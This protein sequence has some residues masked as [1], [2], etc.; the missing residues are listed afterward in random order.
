MLEFGFG[1]TF[2]LAFLRLFTTEERENESQKNVKIE[3]RKEKR[4]TKT[5]KVFIFVEG[6][7]REV[8]IV[9]NNSFYLFYEWQ[10]NGSK[11]EKSIRELRG[12]RK[13]KRKIFVV[14]MKINLRIFFFYFPLFLETVRKLKEIRKSITK[15]M[16]FSL[17]RSSYH[18]SIFN[19]W[20]FGL[21]S[22]FVRNEHEEGNGSSEIFR[23]ALLWAGDGKI[24]MRRLG[25]KF[26]FAPKGSIGRRNIWQINR[27]I[28]WNRQ[29][30]IF[31]PQ[32][33]FSLFMN[34]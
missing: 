15:K 3:S 34:P 26:M 4:P 12:L 33:A 23:M 22:S 28:C 2:Y 29:N 5:L 32:A 25:W 19:Q 11:V 14:P 17:P 30:L 10:W 7:R 16:T 1:F 6:R 27:T 13:R 21:S 8:E 9:S 24:A 31:D 18:K 20:A